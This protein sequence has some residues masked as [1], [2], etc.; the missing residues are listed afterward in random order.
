MFDTDLF[1]YVLYA[2]GRRVKNERPPPPAIKKSGLAYYPPLPA[3]GP[4]C[5]RHGR[6]DIDLPKETTYVTHVLE[7]YFVSPFSISSGTRPP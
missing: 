1:K 3:P 4:W 6:S 2:S 5:V 7:G